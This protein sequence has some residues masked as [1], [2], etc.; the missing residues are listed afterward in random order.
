MACCSR[1]QK[2]YHYRSLDCEINVSLLRPERRIYSLPRDF[3]HLTGDS[4]K[5]KLEIVDFAVCL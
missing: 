5:M 3:Q 4:Y 2:G 1:Q